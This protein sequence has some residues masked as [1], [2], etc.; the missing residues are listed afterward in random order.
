MS[1]PMWGP[2]RPLLYYAWRKLVIED[3]P[4]SSPLPPHDLHLSLPFTFDGATSRKYSDPHMTRASSE[5]STSLTLSRV[6]MFLLGCFVGCI[7]FTPAMNTLIISTN[8][9]RPVFHLSE[10]HGNDWSFDFVV[11]KL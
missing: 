9:K 7:T 5:N 8:C 4:K 6:L 11:L 2:C 3:V 1:P 10:R